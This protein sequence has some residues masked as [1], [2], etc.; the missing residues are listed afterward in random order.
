MLRSVRTSGSE[1]LLFAGSCLRDAANLRQNLFLAKD[2]IFLFI[3]L[4][5]VAGIFAEQDP[6]AGLYVER[7]AAALFVQLAGAHRDYFGFLRL[8]LGRIR[9]ND[10]AFRGFFLFESS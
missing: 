8:L 9:D 3:D 1:K 2:Q 6:I 10:S 5:V 4:D 7:N